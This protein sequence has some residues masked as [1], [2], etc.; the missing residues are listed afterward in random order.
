VA[1]S[2]SVLNPAVERF[3]ALSDEMNRTYGKKFAAP[4]E[5]EEGPLASVILRS[6]S[7][8]SPARPTA[9]RLSTEGR[10]VGVCERI[11]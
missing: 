10:K 6:K 11:R 3:V 5:A 1:V 8:P 2:R 7:S 4:G 9:G